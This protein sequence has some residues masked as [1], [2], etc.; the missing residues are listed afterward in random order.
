MILYEKINVIPMNA[1][2]VLPD[3][4][5]LVDG[6]KIVYIGSDCPEVSPQTDRINCEGKYVIPGLCD[7]H[8]HLE[9][10][11]ENGKYSGG[12]WAEI[13]RTGIDWNQYIKVYLACG[14]TQVRN[15]SGTP[16]LLRLKKAIENNEFEG[17]HIR[18]LSP[19]IDGK[20]PLW[21]ASIETKTDEESIK[22]VQ[23]AAELG[24]DEIKVYNN[25]LP[26]QLD[27]IIVTA[28]QYG[29]KV[30]GHVP[31]PVSMNHCLASSFYGYEHAKAIFKDFV[32]IAAVMHKTITATLVTEKSMEIYADEKACEDMLVLGR[33]RH[34]SPGLLK[35]WDEQP[36]MLRNHDFRLDRTYEQYRSDMVRFFR[37]GGILLAGTDAAFPFAFP[38]YSLHDELVEFVTGGL[39]P[40]EALLT[41]T[42]LPAEFMEISDKRGTI[43]IGK[44]ADMVFLNTNPLEDI[45]NTTD[46]FGVSMMGRWYDQKELNR[47]LDDVDKQ[48]EKYYQLESK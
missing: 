14:I 3:Q 13:E 16:E 12:S 47:L 44:E 21:K 2:G 5:L 24:Y 25:L 26:S 48:T 18:C 36:K 41:A 33:K 29:L 15:M 40:Y 17:P 38:G 46:I 45:H 34:L 27:A 4:Y 30:S 1:E 32:D 9:S 22:A 20:N 23:D 7:M 28:A 6:N 42:R 37:N 43:E 8:V 11:D 35:S 31:I 39:T 10:Q 19:I